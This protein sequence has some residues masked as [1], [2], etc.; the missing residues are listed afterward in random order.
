MENHKIFPISNKKSLFVVKMK[1][2][3]QK[4]DEKCG[5]HVQI[6]NRIA[7]GKDV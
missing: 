2:S 6:V 1:K 5:N 4:N 3:I 7:S